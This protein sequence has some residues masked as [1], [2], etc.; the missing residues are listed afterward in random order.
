LVRIRNYVHSVAKGV[1]VEDMGF[2][3][4]LNGVD[5]GKLFFEHV[6]SVCTALTAALRLLLR[7]LIR[8]AQTDCVLFLFWRWF[9]GLVLV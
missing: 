8:C 5:N 6:V 4:G 1:R 7:P 3:M 2:K 9:G